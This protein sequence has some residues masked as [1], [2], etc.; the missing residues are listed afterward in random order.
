MKALYVHDQK[1][2]ALVLYGHDLD[3]QLVEALVAEFQA[4]GKPAFAVDQL[5]LHGGPA[6]ICEKCRQAG[7]KIA[8]G[9]VTALQLTAEEEKAT[10]LNGAI[11]MV[12]TEI[13]LPTS[14]LS[15]LGKPICTLFSLMPYL[16]ALA[17]ITYGLAYFLRSESGQ[18]RGNFNSPLVIAQL[19]PMQTSVTP[20]GI[21]SPI[22][23]ASP[24][25]SPTA[26]P[27]PTEVEPTP[28]DLPTSPAEPACIDALSIT[29]DD[30]GQTICVTGVVYRAEKNSG[31]FMITFSKDWGN[32]YLLSYNREWNEAQAGACIQVTGEIEMLGTIP[33][34]A[35]GYQNDLSLC[36]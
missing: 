20:T 30:A 31:V 13:A 35:F 29:A 21:P 14:L 2:G 16:A 18:T 25:S 36:P 1:E 23:T 24:S 11:G 33:V 4:Q 26:L 12:S 17:L 6:E 3:E 9:T 19:T 5:G 7:E 10:S 34:I 32:F 27:T 28:T 8:G 22:A 15:R